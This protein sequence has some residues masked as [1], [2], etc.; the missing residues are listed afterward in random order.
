MIPRPQ[1]TWLALAVLG[2]APALGQYPSPQQPAG[3]TIRLR[4][5]A[6]TAQPTPQTPYAAPREVLVPAPA[7]T[8]QV[9]VTRA[10]PQAPSIVLQERAVAAPRRFEVREGKPKWCHHIWRSLAE[11]TAGRP[12]LVELA[13]E[14]P[15]PALILGQQQAQVVTLEPAAG[16]A[17]A[18]DLVVEVP[19]EDLPVF[20]RGLPPVPKIAPTPGAI[21]PAPRKALPDPA[22]PDA[23]ATA[24]VLREAV[25]ELRRAR[26]ALEAQ[27][28]D[29]APLPPEEPEPPTK[30]RSKA[31]VRSSWK[32]REWE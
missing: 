25:D 16:T 5:P 20:G 31:E 9:L 21:E 30:V 15:A 23:G 19:A 8:P 1:K 3:R 29:R 27:T 28:E 2:G 12:R 32:P 18:Q 10:A 17:P 26:Q 13:A 4:L 6:A 22:Q 14:E 11:R 24:E 7:P